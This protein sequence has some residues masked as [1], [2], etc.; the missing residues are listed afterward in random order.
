MALLPHDATWVWTD[1]SATGGV[2]GGGAGALIINPHEDRHELRTPAG[3]LGSSFRAKM[4]APRAGLDHLLEVSHYPKDPIVV[5]TDSRSALVA[6]REGPAA[7]RSLQEGE[8]WSCLLAIAAEGRPIYTQWVPSHCRIDG[9]KRLTHWQEKRLP[10]RRRTPC[11]TSPLFT[12]RHPPGETT[13]CKGETGLSWQHPSGERLV[14]GADGGEVSTIDR[15]HG[16]NSGRCTPD[17]DWTLE[18][19]GTVLPRDRPQPSCQ[20][21]RNID[22]EATRCPLCGEE[23]DTPRHI[24][25]TCL[26]MMGVRLPA[27][28]NI[29]PTPEEIRRSDVVAALVAAFRALQT[30]YVAGMPATGGTHI[31]NSSSSWKDLTT[32]ITWDTLLT[33]AAACCLNLSLVFMCIPRSSTAVMP[34]S[35]PFRV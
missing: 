15:E 1:G 23:A 27:V 24:L 3:S 31:N 25:M 14:Q 16:Q 26:G 5:C 7:Q 11:S 20:Q 33:A 30:Q 22:C 8:I 35:V 17:E 10:W 19:L 4:I 9:T 28:G 32:T 13:R 2:I 34:S 6:L 18:W 12:G 21:C 29:L